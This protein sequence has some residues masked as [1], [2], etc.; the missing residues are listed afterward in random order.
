MNVLITGARGM[1]AQAVN[2]VA[3]EHGHATTGLPRTLLDVTNEAAVRS[4]LSAC[5]PDV[6]IQCAG[7]T[8]VDQAETERSAAFSVNATGAGY[9]ARACAEIGAAVVYP[10]TD[11]VFSGRAA[12][13]YTPHDAVAPVNVYGASKAAGEVVVRGA[14]RHYVVRTSWLYGA[15]GPNFVTTILQRARSGE[16]LRVVND[17]RG[18]PTWTRDL[19]RTILLLLELRAPAG[20]YHACNQGEATWYQLACASLQLAGVN[21][22]V[23][24]INTEAAGRSARR[25]GYSVLDCSGTE[26]IVGPLRPWRDALAD[27]LL[28]GI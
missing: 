27:A 13:P 1:L 11:Y 4:L 8:R 25:P 15:G 21:V 28:E 10:S 26:R 14:P 22:P 5:K 6:V 9:V 18:C 17:Q 2:R 3:T 24:A 16:P 19:A 7:Y 23:T 12:Q 20:T